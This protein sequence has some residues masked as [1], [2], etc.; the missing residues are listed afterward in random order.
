MSTARG[1]AGMTVGSKSYR[2][3]V[4]LQEGPAT[5]A[6]VADTT[7]LTKRLASGHLKNLFRKHKIAREP[8]YV[9]RAGPGR[10]SVWL[11][12]LPSAKRIVAINDAVHTGL[13]V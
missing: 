5:T 7:G 2:C 1:V 3:M 9:R 6:E 10:S 12:M 13:P 8:F 11:W 4:A